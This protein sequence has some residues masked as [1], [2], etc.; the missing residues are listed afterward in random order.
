MLL[1]IFIY[2]GWDTAVTVNEETEDPG[3]APGGQR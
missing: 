3:E 2:W 1:A